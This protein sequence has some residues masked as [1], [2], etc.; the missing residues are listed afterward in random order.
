[1]MMSNR[2]SALLDQEV[3]ALFVSASKRFT[4]LPQIKMISMQYQADSYLD[5]CDSVIEIAQ[6]M[7][8]RCE[9]GVSKSIR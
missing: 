5:T 4:N 1:M 6:E 2:F 9:A 8:K 7:K 3:R